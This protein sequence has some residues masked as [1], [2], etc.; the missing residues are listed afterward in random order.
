MKL[1]YVIWDNKHVENAVVLYRLQGVENKWE[2]NEGIP[3]SADFTAEATFK[4]DLD[5]L[6]N[7]ILTDNLKNKDMLVVASRRLK[8]FLEEWNLEKV[9]YLPVTI[10]DH[11]GKPIQENYF[12]IHPIHPIPCLDVEKCG[13]TW[14]PLDEEAIDFIERMVIDES[15]IDTRTQSITVDR[16]LFRPKYFDCITLVRRD[17]AEAID[18]AG[19][20]GVEWMEI[21]ECS[22]YP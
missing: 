10:I 19:F 1:N 21:D 15:L 20:T 7:T 4:M 17:L 9:E 5:L 3:R 13:A 12:I 8:E 11:K 2:L 16:K 14:S 18:E 22:S 6:Y